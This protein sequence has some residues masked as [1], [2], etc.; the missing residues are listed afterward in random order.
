MVFKLEA[1][2]L[3]VGQLTE[4]SRKETKGVKGAEVD[5]ADTMKSL[6]EESAQASSNTGVKINIKAIKVT[7][8][9]TYNTVTSID[10]P[11]EVTE[12]AN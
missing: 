3:I 10:I 5:M 8:E 6:L 4:K 9:N 12:A 1:R 2:F 11:K 7:S